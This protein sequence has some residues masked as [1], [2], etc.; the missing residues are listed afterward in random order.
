MNHISVEILT[1]PAC[2]F[3]SRG[4]LALSSFVSY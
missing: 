4:K 3:V 1:R 2:L